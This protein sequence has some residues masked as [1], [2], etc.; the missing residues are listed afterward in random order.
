MLCT[1]WPLRKVCHRAVGIRVELSAHVSTLPVPSLSEAIY[2]YQLEGW[3]G[4]PGWLLNKPLWHVDGI[5]VFGLI[6]TH[7]RINRV[8]Q[9]I[10]TELLLVFSGI[11]N[12]FP[13]N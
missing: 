6:S 7:V 10:N 3:S 9:L 4:A 2:I 5:H 1:L 11:W 12:Q 8:S 13:L